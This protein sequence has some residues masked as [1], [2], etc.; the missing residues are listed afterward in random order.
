MM[1]AVAAT[2]AIII[3]I[4]FLRMTCK[5]YWCGG[6][7]DHQQM[8]IVALFADVCCGCVDKSVLNDEGPYLPATRALTRIVATVIASSMSM[9]WHK[10]KGPQNGIIYSFTLIAILDS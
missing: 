3:V 8:P 1:T 9:L 2:A 5:S 6:S 4:F 10:I 7:G